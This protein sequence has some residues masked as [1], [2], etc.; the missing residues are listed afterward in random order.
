MFGKVLSKVNSRTPS[1]VRGQSIVYQPELDGI[2]GL[3]ILIIVL[4]HMGYVGKQYLGGR[5]FLAVDIFFA[6]SGFL[7]TQILLTYRAKSIG[8]RTFYRRRIS[9]LYPILLISVVGVSAYFSG[10]WNFPSG[11]PAVQSVLYIKNFYHWGGVF[12]PMWSLAAEEQFYLI[13]PI[14]LFL[15]L[16]FL[17]GNRLT[18]VLMIWLTIVWFAGWRNAAPSYNFNMDGT[19]NLVIFRP[20]I[21][22][23]GALVA[24]HREKLEEFV[25]RYR[26]LVYAWLVIF[27]F[28]TITTQFPPLAGISTAMLILILSEPVRSVCWFAR[29]LQRI[30][31]FR[32]LAF[33]GLLSYSIYI[34][35]LPMI[36][37]LSGHFTMGSVGPLWIFSAKLFAVALVS[38]YLVERPL[39][40]IAVRSQ[41]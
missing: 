35:H 29:G 15:G 20:S 39:L 22:V 40:K 21:I 28:F 31:G 16:K 38:F 6:L 41:R 32:P 30:F 33:I 24:L 23:V 36:F 3:A 8:L 1:Q 17:K 5:G 34:W 11:W 18:V 19:F 37:I 12:G 13:F 26:N 7:I 9:R 2:R 14:V 10:E 4:H 27:I 25:A